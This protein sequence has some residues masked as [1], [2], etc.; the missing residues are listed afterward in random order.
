LLVDWP[1]LLVLAYGLNNVL[2]LILAACVFF[3][4]FGGATGYDQAWGAYWFQMDYPLRFL[5]VTVPIGALGTLHLT[6]ER[7]PLARWRGFAKVWISI[8]LF[9][10]E[11]ALWLL[12][13]FGNFDLASDWHLAGAGELLVFNL[14]WTAGNLALIV[15]GTRLSFRMLTGYGT[16]FF[17]IQL[18]TQF[19]AHL[20]PGLGLTGCLLIG[21]GSALAALV[22]LERRYRRLIQN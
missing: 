17:I 16:T 14:L 7:G 21:G 15:A 18:Y 2:V 20:G 6:A 13:L 12:S 11:M 10:A 8:A 4:W 22:W 5:A 1:L 9:L 19:F 3:T